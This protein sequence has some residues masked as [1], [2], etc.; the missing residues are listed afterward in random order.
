MKTDIGK[1]CK[2]LS[3]GLCN[4]PQVPILSEFELDNQV[5]LLVKIIDKAINE[6]TPKQRLCAR[7]IP[8]FD[9]ECKEAQMRA[10]RFKK[11]YNRNPSAETWEEYRLAGAVKGRLIDKKKKMAIASI[12]KKLAIP[13]RL[14]GKP[15]KLLEDWAQFILICL[16]FNEVTKQQPTTLKKKLKYSKTHFFPPHLFHILLTYKTSH[17]RRGLIC[18]LLQI[19]KLSSQF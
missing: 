2:S 1:L 5:E 12:V 6:S 17:I 16:L 11:T 19:R 7:S 3:Q 18:Q 10:R 14:C 8:G 9:E 13:Q 15:A 4:F